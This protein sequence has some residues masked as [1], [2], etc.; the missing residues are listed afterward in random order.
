MIVP[1]DMFVIMTTLYGGTQAGITLESLFPA[2][3]Q[4]HSPNSHLTSLPEFHS[5]FLY[6]VKFIFSPA[7]LWFFLQIFANYLSV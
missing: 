5:A 7:V 4:Q 3:K 1:S 6:F 2:H